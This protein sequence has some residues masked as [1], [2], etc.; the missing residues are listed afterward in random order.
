MPPLDPA[1]LAEALA[2][3]QGGGGMPA[4]APVPSPMAQV[5]DSGV[6]TSALMKVVELLSAV[7]GIGG[8]DPMMGAPPPSL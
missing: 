3:R 7:A 5:A 6:G 1:M 2:A 8:T 4:A